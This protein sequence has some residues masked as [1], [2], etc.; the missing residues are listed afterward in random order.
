MLIITA[1]QTTQIDHNAP[2]TLSDLKTGDSARVVSL[3]GGR[4]VLCR[5]ASLG[6]TPGV[7]V[8][9]L[10]NSGRGPLIAIVRGTRV[11]LGRQ[12]ARKTII[13]RCEE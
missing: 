11:A 12:E 6:F 13:Q 3:T 8:T 2:L 4:G 7:K 5:M 1:D 10:Q 9:V